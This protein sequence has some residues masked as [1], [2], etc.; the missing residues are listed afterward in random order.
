MKLIKY[1][2]DNYTV[3]L[4]A[5]LLH[6]CGYVKAKLKVNTNLTNLNDNITFKKK[7][8]LKYMIS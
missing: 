1:F 6:D 7:R 2:S 8:L 3:N 5:L 4:L